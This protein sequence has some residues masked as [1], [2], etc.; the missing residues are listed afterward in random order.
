MSLGVLGTLGAVDT[1]HAQSACGNNP[2]SRVASVTVCVGGKSFG[3]FAA[4]ANG[5]LAS[6]APT[7]IDLGGGSSFTVSALF[8]SDPFVQFSFGSAV[9]LP[10]AFAFDVY[11][12]TPVVGGPYNYATS[13]LKSTLSALVPVTAAGSAGLSLG[14]TPAYLVGLADATNLGVDFG[15]SPCSLSTTTSTTCVNGGTSN[16][17]AAFSPS[18]L[19]A[20]LSY[21]QTNVGVAE[22]SSLW[23]GQVEILAT[24]VPEPSSVILLAAG[25]LVVGATAWRKRSFTM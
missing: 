25:L 9:F 14:A 15:T 10:G 19:T 17:F 3:N 7:T 20:H 2:N 21:T 16:T 11:F 5:K 13:R 23:D 4:V 12:N 24:T 18:M 1:V 22:S 8:N 6:L